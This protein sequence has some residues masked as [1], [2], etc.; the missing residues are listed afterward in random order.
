MKF[1]LMSDLHLEFGLARPKDHNPVALDDDKYTTLILAGDICT[2]LDAEGFIF[3]MCKR[4]HKVVYVLGN[5]E[6]YHK[7]Y[8]KL[9]RQ[10]NEYPG[11]PNNFILLD[12][13]VA[14]IDDPYETGKYARLVGGTLWTNFRNGDYLA[15]HRARAGM[16]DFYCIKWKEKNDAGKYY[17]RKLMPEDTIRAHKQTLFFITETL[18]EPFDGP[19]VVVSHHLPHPLCVDPVFKGNGLNSAYMSNLDDVIA[20]NDIA[21]W[22]HGHTHANVDVEIHDTRILCNPRGYDPHDLNPG[23]IDDLTFEV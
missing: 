8:N 23:F 12:D 16:N 13:H 17:K 19:T 9:R 4:F 6:F 2:G 20:D 5:H 21:V 14:I 15:M 1:R 7:E 10:W 22:C 18:R 3:A 11:L